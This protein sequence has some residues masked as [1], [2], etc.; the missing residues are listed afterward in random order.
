MTTIAFPALRH[1]YRYKKTSKEGH[2]PGLY[3]PRRSE[4]TSGHSSSRPPPPPTF[5]HHLKHPLRGHFSTRP[6]VRFIGSYP[7]HGLLDAMALPGD[8]YRNVF[9]TASNSSSAHASDRSHG[10]CS[11]SDDRLVRDMALLAVGL[12]TSH[13]VRHRGRGRV[14]TRFLLPRP[15]HE[16]PPSAVDR[17]SRRVGHRRG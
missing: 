1:N 17:Q 13:A 15:R 5:L 11:H 8:P 4:V 10:R 7:R 6:P 12:H 14:R 9:I 2:P 3:L 16:G